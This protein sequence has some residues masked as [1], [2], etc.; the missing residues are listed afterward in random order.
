VAIV[1]TVDPL[2]ETTPPSL[3][4]AYTT[5]EVVTYTLFGFRHCVEVV[6]VETVDPLMETTPPP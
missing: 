1:E 2:M 5:P 6:R 3:H 4:V